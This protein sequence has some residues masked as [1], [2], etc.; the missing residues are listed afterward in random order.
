MASW[1]LIQKLRTETQDDD[2]NDEHDE[3]EEECERIRRPTTER[4]K[5][6]RLDESKGKGKERWQP[7]D[8]DGEYDVEECDS[9]TR[10]LTQQA[11][12]VIRDDDETNEHDE[13]EAERERL[14]GQPTGGAEKVQLDDGGGDDDD[15]DLGFLGGQNWTNMDPDETDPYDSRLISGYIGDYSREFARDEDY[16]QQLR[17]AQE[18]WDFI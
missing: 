2:E 7:E 5:R 1:R 10:L 17:A 18:L 9:A 11:Q 15:G 16:D 3:D 8:E 12:T 4:A 13:N 6:V 14:H